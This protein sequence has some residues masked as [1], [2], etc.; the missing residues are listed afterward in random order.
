MNI[1]GII[2][3]KNIL[4]GYSLNSLPTQHRNVNTMKTE[5]I[6]VIGRA[7]GWRQTGERLGEQDYKRAI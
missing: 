2:L 6:S 3:N 1:K 5:M 7:Y 4:K